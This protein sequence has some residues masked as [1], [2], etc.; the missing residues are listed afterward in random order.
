M[1]WRGAVLPGGSTLLAVTQLKPERD[2]PGAPSPRITASRVDPRVAE[3]IVIFALLVAVI[4]AHTSNNHA[5]HDWITGL[6]QNL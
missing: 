3:N 4:Q 6:I 5:S 2:V 1:S